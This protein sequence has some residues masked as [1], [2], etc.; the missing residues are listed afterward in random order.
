LARIAG[1][2]ERTGRPV[3]LLRDGKD[4]AML[5]PASSALVAGYRSIPALDPPRPWKEVT[6]IAAEEHALH[7]AREGLSGH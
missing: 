4:V 6:E 3:R 7:V 5:V 1:E 2:V